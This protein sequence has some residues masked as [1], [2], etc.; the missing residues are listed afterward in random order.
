MARDMPEP[1][2]FPS[3]DSCQKRFLWSHIVL[4][5][6]LVVDLAIQ[7][8]DMEMFPLS[9]GL[10]NFVSQQAGS[11]SHSH[12]GTSVHVSIKLKVRTNTRTRVQ[13]TRNYI[14]NK[15]SSISRLGILAL[16]LTKVGQTPSHTSLL[17]SSTPHNARTQPLAHATHTRTR[18]NTR[19][20]T[21]TH[22]HARAHTH[23]RIHSRARERAHTHTH[24]HTHIHITHTNKNTP[25]MHT[26]AHT[27]MYAH[28][29]TCHT[30]IHTHNTHTHLS[31][32]HI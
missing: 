13:N 6:H 1:C 9:I 12:R 31:L 23:T 19:T 25:H 18:M 5:P 3:L 8:G 28:T 7:P 16:C 29:T 15:H 21:H 20:R 27:H 4:F 2:E 17:N 14:H 10:D 22:T 11:I 24:T 30:H 26:H 32:I